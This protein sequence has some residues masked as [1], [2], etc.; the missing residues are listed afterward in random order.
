MKS[1]DIQYIIFLFFKEK[2][3]ENKVSQGR[4]ESVGGLESSGLGTGGSTLYRKYIYIYVCLFVIIIG[5]K[6][7]GILCDMTGSGIALRVQ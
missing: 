3:K 4:K 6:V 5:K 2:V 7:A 1:M